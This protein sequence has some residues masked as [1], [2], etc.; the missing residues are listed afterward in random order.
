M[1]TPTPE[2]PALT[3][4]RKSGSSKVKVA[5]S[6]IDGILRGKYLHIDKFLGAAEPRAAASASATSS[7]AGTVA[8]PVLRQHHAHR[9]AARL[10][11]R[12][13]APRPRRRSAT[14]R[15]TATCRSSSASSSSADRSAVADLPAPDAQA[16]ARARREAG[17]RGRCAGWSSSGSTSPRRRRSWAEK[18]GVDPEPI[19]PGMFG[20][21]LLRMNR[22]REFFNALMDEMRR[23][24]RADRGPAHRDRAGRLRGRDRLRRSA[25]G[26]P[27]ARSCSRPAPRRSARASA[28]CR[29][30]WPSGTR[31]YPGCS[32]H[33]H[34]SLKEGSD[35]KTNLFYDAKSARADEHAVRE[36]P[37]RPGR[38]PDGVRADV[39][40]DDQQLQAPR[41]RLLGAGQADLGH[42]QPH[43]ELSRASPAARRR[44]GSRR[45]ARAPTST[46]TS[47]WRRCVA[48]G[49][50]GVEKGLKLTAPPITGTN[51]GAERHPARAAHAD[52]D[53][54]H[55]Q[56]VRDR[57]RLVRRRLRRPLRRDARLGVAAVAGRR[58][59]LGTE[60]LLRDHLSMAKASM[61]RWGRVRSAVLALACAVAALGAGPRTRSRCA[62]P[63]RSI[64]R[65]WIRT[66][67]RCSITR[68]S[69]PDLRVAGQPRQE[70]VLEPALALSWQAVDAEDLALQAAPGR[71]ASTTA[72]RS[73]AD[74]AVFS[75]E[76]ALGAT[77]QRSFQL[78]GVTGAQQ[79]RR[80]DDRHLARGARRGAAREAASACRI[81]S[82]AWATKHKRRAAAGLQRQ[83]GDLR[84]RA[85]PTA[86]GRSCSSATSPTSA[87]C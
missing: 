69:S 59:R 70:F 58:D 79:G 12:A 21:S 34:Q 7:S 40:A 87:R 1:T 42:R 62:S 27:T 78:R 24:R 54:A 35:G 25:R 18:Q 83:A 75:I 84:G 31:K 61:A 3:A 60:A 9:L 39:L 4:V 30:S 51:E 16:R 36:L 17:L 45:A 38:L 14:C 47:R 29:A 63:A 71:D 67:W 46:R 81:M 52:R 13:R 77:S 76:R 20:Y 44:R 48:A 57:A 74:D 23:L 28:S 43:G 82:R 19:T 80:A 73:T 6:D 2:H 11:R 86:P 53:D 22:N 5:V 37:R 15:G 85:T 32:G 68:G 41:R 50:H 26:R 66:R 64:R 49:L 33:I 65:R 55:L 56:G 10:S 72:R 8:R